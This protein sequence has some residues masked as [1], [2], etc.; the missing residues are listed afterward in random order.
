MKNVLMITFSWPPLMRAGVWRPLRL[1]KYLPRNGW[2]PTIVTSKGSE[3]GGVADVAS[4][5]CEGFEVH[6][7]M[8][9]GDVDVARA[10]SRVG[11]PVLRLLRKERGWL[12]EA[13]SWRT[14]RFVHFPDWGTCLNRWISP[15]VAESIRLAKTGRYSA[16]YVTS[17][18]NSMAIVAGIVATATRLPVVLDFRDP[19][20]QNF[21]YRYS[22]MRHALARVLEAWCI[23]SARKVIVVTPRLSAG[24]TELYP[25]ARRK[26]ECISN[27][28]D[29]DDIPGV[30]GDGRGD[31]F[32]VTLM[33][34]SHEDPR[35]LFLA[36]QK[37][38]CSHPAFAEKFVFRWI[39][40]SGGAVY[41]VKELGLDKNV[42]L[43]G[44][45]PH[46]QAVQQAAR[47]DALWL[48]VPIGRTAEYVSCLKTFEYLALRRPVLGTVPATCCARSIV[49][50]A[51][52]CRLIASREPEDIAGL[53]VG[54]FRDWQQ[55]RLVCNADEDYITKFRADNLTR[56]LAAV[57]HE[58]ALN[59]PAR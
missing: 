22:G 17:P 29:P 12:E 47:S 45:L 18:P 5:G 28:Y 37:G 53:L 54:A 56:R 49:E 44:C 52:T 21:T 34:T 30:S 55:G 35:C 26:I 13:I 32:V 11:G 48:E 24:V 33:G 42:E 19:W 58:M 15:L 1:A 2:M 6:R 27:G 43:L 31:R 23:R 46:G 9:R 10:I 20:T 50:R 16:I 41:V 7:V 57:L 8:P 3:T 4:T 14:R 25:F 36:I 38:A 40:D 39:G 59:G 51:C